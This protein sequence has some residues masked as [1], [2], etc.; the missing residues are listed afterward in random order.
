MNTSLVN[1][2]G[3]VQVKNNIFVSIS[4]QTYDKI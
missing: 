4:F 1:E 2:V 3:S